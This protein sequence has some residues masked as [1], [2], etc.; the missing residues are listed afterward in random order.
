MHAQYD[1]LIDVDVFV[2]RF[3]GVEWLAAV[4]LMRDASLINSWQLSNVIILG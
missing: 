4:Q 3:R 2:W 1:V